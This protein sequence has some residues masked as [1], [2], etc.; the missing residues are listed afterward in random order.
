M[1]TSTCSHPHSNLPEGLAY[2]C[3]CRT[4][5]SGIVHRGTLDNI[6]RDE[7][8]ESTTSRALGSSFH[9]MALASRES[10]DSTLSIF[11]HSSERRIMDIRQLAGYLLSKPRLSN[12]VILDMVTY[13]SRPVIGFLKHMFIILRVRQ[14]HGGDGRLRLERR[15]E[16]PYSVSFVCAGMQGPAKD[17]VRHNLFS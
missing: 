4:S 9:P 17:E 16:D 6:P 10:V 3:L 1:R 8:A 14:A 11:T 13:R 12:T 7:N 5:L 2:L 15:P